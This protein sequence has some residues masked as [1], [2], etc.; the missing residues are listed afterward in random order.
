MIDDTVSTI[1]SSAA[2]RKREAGALSLFSRPIHNEVGQFS[3]RVREVVGT[4]VHEFEPTDFWFI[5]LQPSERRQA[6]QDE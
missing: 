2:Q 6:H 5:Q 3:K 4:G 1:A